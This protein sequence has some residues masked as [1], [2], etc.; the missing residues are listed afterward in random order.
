M[1]CTTSVPDESAWLAQF[2][3]PPGSDSPAGAARVSEELVD[4]AGLVSDAS[5]IHSPSRRNVVSWLPPSAAAATPLAG[6]VVLLHGLHEHCFRHH[7]LASL[8]ATS[9]NMCVYGVDHFGHGRSE[10]LR[11]M[12]YDWNKTIAEV[13]AFV[14]HVRA[15]HPDTSVPLFIFAHSCGALFTTLTIPR[16]SAAA[17]PRAVVLSATALIAGPDSG[18]PF[19][20][21]CLFPLTELK[22]FESLVGLLAAV[23]PTGDGA[24]IIREGLMHDEAERALHKAD[25]RIY[26][27]CIRTK[28][29]YELV[30]MQNQVGR[31]SV[32][33]SWCALLWSSSDSPPPPPHTHTHRS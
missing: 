4:F 19:G 7:E 30:K 9:G 12:I 20:F 21:K 24:P 14:E 26:P 22:S 5:T 27:G 16:L 23:A 15:K 18:S 32:R 3:P 13:V 28:T 25:P 8:L 2:I 1:G 10:G 31:P 6:I 29:A 17:T 11:G 33:P